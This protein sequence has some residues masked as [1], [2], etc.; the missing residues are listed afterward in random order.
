[1]KKSAFKIYSFIIALSLFLCCLNATVFAG[2]PWDSGQWRET[3]KNLG[4][5]LYPYVAQSGTS[6][7]NI[8]VTKSG[9]IRIDF[10]NLTAG[11]S[12]YFSG[13]A[14]VPTRTWVIWNGTGDQITP[15]TTGAD[16]IQYS[17]GMNQAWPFDPSTGESNTYVLEILSGM[18]GNGEVAGETIYVVGGV[19][20]Y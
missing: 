11:A 9:V 19:T 15:N 2:D 6:S 16:P 4:G 5:W 12:I 14:D 13:T 8:D 10:G 3:A 7:V 20:I 18:W 17:T 1:M